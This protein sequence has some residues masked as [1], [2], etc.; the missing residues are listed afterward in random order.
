M[1]EMEP[2]KARENEY[3]FA[4]VLT[5]I[6]DL[7]PEAENALFE[8]GCDDATLS[9][10]FGRVFVTFSRTASSLKAAILSAIRDVKTANVGADVLR[11]E[12]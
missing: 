8:A 5:G 3:D 12:L 9:V 4:L 10:R 1:N 11:V 2:N 6:T 7:T